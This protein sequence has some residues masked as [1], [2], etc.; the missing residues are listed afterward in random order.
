M[1]SLATAFRYFFSG[2]PFR[3]VYSGVAAAEVPSSERE[4]LEDSSEST[5]ELGA[6][7][8]AISCVFSM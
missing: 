7:Y 6:M 2:V 8:V 4:R 1:F 5:A 3:Y